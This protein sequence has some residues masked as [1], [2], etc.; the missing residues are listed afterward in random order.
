VLAPP[1]PATRP[2]PI[3]PR[4]PRVPALN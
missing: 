4:T 2:M 3:P 1:A